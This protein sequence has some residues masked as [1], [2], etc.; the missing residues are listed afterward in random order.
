MLLVAIIIITIVICVCN[1]RCP[2]YKRRQRE[3]PPVVVI[4]G[5]QPAPEEDAHESLSLM[6]N[7]QVDTQKG[8]CNIVMLPSLYTLATQDYSTKLVNN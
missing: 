5:A 6:N 7:D 1:K 3:Q 4:D 2:L 8:A